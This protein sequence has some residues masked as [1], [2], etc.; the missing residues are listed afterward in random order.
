MKRILYNEL[1]L[2]KE[3]LDRK[4]LLLQGARQVGKTYLVKKF[5]YN[6]FKKFVYLNFEQDT[7]LIKLFDGDL[8]PTKLV[9]RLSLYIGKPIVAKDTL[10]FFDEVQ[11]SPRTIT[12]LKYF[13]EMAPEYYVIAAGSLLGVSIS[14]ASSFPVGKVN[15][16]TLYPL[17][18]VEYLMAI[19]ED[20]LAEYIL[21]LTSDSRIPDAI[22]E[23][24]SKHY[25]LYLYLGGMPEVVQSYIDKKDIQKV[26]NIQNDILSSYYRDFSKYA[27]KSQTIKNIE[28]WNSIPYQ[29]A[30]ENKKFK[31]SDVKKKARASM[32]AQSIEWLQ[33]AGLVHIVYNVST[34]KL[35][36][37]GY[38]DQNKFKLFMLDTGLLGAMLQLT[39]DI[40][41]KKTAL[42][43]EYNGAF[44]EN[45]V[46]MSLAA[47]SNSNLYYWTSR[48]EAEVD[49]LVV[50]DNEILPIEIKS[51]TSRNLK[52][53]QSYASKYSPKTI[54]RSS[55]RNLTKT[56]N[57]INIP[58]YAIGQ[59][60]SIL[61]S[62]S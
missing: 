37:G 27:A 1:V 59:W 57:F 41:L 24:L 19:S 32:F 23:K 14:K 22:H 56:N 42:F 54:C 9:A 10:L 38:A 62:D 18:F 17:V 33:L 36:L 6:E 16:M 2:W 12:S 48:G 39:S 34:P 52:S 13:Q 60:K 30:K 11:V 51:G 47:N 53:L 8:S 46:A 40:I 28:V 29:L 26:R 45:Y 58:L 49:F 55:P 20:I 31:Y 4:P 15:F 25:K 5:G 7:E 43:T 44:I 35:P 50:K 21:N 3:D 61:K